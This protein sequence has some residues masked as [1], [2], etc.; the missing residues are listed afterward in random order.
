MT[1]KQKIKDEMLEAIF[2]QTGG[3]SE[4]PKI[5]E[6]CAEIAVNFITSNTVLITPNAVLSD[7]LPLVEHCEDWQH[8]HCDCVGL[9]C[10]K[11]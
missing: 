8:D 1:M 3:R 9:Y 10:M 6:I 11:K 5:A 4:N 2:V 7:S